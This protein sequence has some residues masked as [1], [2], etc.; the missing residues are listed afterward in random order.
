MAAA[1]CGNALVHVNTASIDFTVWEAAMYT[2]LTISKTIQVL[3]ASILVA[4]I[5]VFCPLSANA[6]SKTGNGTKNVQSNSAK[7]GTANSP[8]SDAGKSGT[9]KGAAGG[10]GSTGPLKK[11]SDTD[12]GINQNIK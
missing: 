4:C 5:F 12:A 3:V 10:G 11:A 9:A 1:R 6:A 8:L 7:R 2:P